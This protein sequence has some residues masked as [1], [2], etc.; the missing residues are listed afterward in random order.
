MIDRTLEEIKGHLEEYLSWKH[1]ISDTRRPFRCLNPEHEDRHPS[2]SCNKEE[3]RVKCF[4]CGV[5]YDVL[6]L[7]G[8]DYGLADFKEQKAKACELFHITEEWEPTKEKRKP[9]EA[10]DMKPSAA[11]TEDKAV[12]NREKA[13]KARKV[14]EEAATGRGNPAFLEYLEKRGLERETAEA[15]NLGY[16][17]DLWDSKGNPRPALII[18]TGEST[19]TPRYIDG[20]KPK[21]EHRGYSET[22]GRGYGFLNVS[23]LEDTEV[24]SIYIVEGEIDALSIIQA[25]GSAIALGSTAYVK[26]FIDT[27]EKHPEAWEKE[28]L[29]ALDNDLAGWKAI[30]E[31]SSLL[32]QRNLEIRT[33]IVNPAGQYKDANEALLNNPEGFTRAVQSCRSLRTD[34]EI[35]KYLTHAAAWHLQEFRESADRTDTP[36]TPTG[37]RQLDRAL[38]GGLYPGLYV[39]IGNTGTGKSAYAL[40]MA[41]NIAASGQDVLYISLEMTAAEL[42]A[43]NISRHTL[44]IA[45]AEDL[46]R[47]RAKTARGIMD[48]RRYTEHTNADGERAKGYTLEEMNLIERATDKA[49]EYADRLIFIDGLGD[50]PVEAIREYAET[51]IDMRGKPPVVIVDY[52]QILQPHYTRGATEKQ[53]NDY[54]IL[55]LKRISRD[56]KTP[57][58]VLSSTARE[59]YTKAVHVGAAKESGAIEYT[60]DCVL[61]I[62]F[63]GQG[64]SHKGQVDGKEKTIDHATAEWIENE[65]SREPRHLQ[66]KVLKNR[67]AKANQAIPLDYYA[68]FNLLYETEGTNSPWKRADE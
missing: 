40:Q 36:P 58:I 57:V 4:S 5:A 44:E 55:E 23:A 12:E 53:N 18:P 63:W 67:Y 3:N 17:P 68:M 13:Q 65:M 24:S 26:S 42:L 61:G 33:R 60:A 25:G 41:S 7:I 54:A 8:M 28:Y 14:I 48:R 51:H 30:K 62:Q 10:A 15:F 50:V 32:E 20:E 56:L 47:S 19:Y 27:L 45:A 38:D 6:D 9:Q 22:T 37:F 66:V 29:L 34:K 2:M 49:E 39:L 52:L 46:P 35:E 31:F 64:K 59:N 21:T 1:G 16:K 11:D 43:R